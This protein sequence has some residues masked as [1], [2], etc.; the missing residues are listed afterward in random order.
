[1]VMN[2]MPIVRERRNFKGFSHLM[3]FVLRL[4]S[5]EWHRTIIEYSCTALESILKKFINQ[6]GDGCQIF[7][8]KP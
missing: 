6:C 4:T 3:Q 7:G 8:V 5:V 2:E 1:M